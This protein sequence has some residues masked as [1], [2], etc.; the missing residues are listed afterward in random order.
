MPDVDA[1]FA[2]LVRTEDK[3]RHRLRGLGPTT[4]KIR[5]TKRL[6]DQMVIEFAKW[7]LERLEPPLGI[8][9]FRGSPIVV[10][11]PPDHPH[12]FVIVYEA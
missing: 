7:D 2:D 10:D 4:K 3:L 9:S 11:L 6:Y 12:G 1:T 8:Y 5:V